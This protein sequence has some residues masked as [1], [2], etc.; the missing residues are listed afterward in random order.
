MLSFDNKGVLYPC[1]RFMPSSLGD[2]PPITMGKY[3][4]GEFSITE[5]ESECLHCLQCVD[6]KTQSTEECYNCPIAKGCAWCTAYNYQKFGTPNH[7]AT[8]ICW[9][10]KARALA[11]Y[12]FWNR[13][14]EAMHIDKHMDNYME[15]EWIDEILK[16]P[17]Y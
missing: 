10:H 7:R 14:Y 17:E 8:F 13:Y 12:E 11:N 3:E 5:K 16:D 2:V 6:R 9:M 1:L 4:N 15:Q